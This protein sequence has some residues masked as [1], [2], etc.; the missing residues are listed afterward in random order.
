M[1]SPLRNLSFTL[2]LM[3]ALLI[4]LAPCRA[5]ALFGSITVADEIEI[6]KKFDNTIRSQMPF[7]DDPE[8]VA[9]VK[10]VVDRVAA[11]LPPQPF[12]IRSAVVGNGSMNAFAIPGG[13]IY[14]FTGLILG[15]EN[16]D[17]LAAVK[18]GRAHV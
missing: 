13:Y 9:Y 6:G 2:S 16:E 11:A 17:E 15:V 1:H 4:V 14:I 18:I 7:V 3:A 5:W 8:V 10:G 12:P